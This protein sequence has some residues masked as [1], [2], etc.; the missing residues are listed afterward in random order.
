MTSKSEKI[1]HVHNPVEDNNDVTER[2]K[3]WSEV[4]HNSDTE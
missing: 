2:W 4:M 1:L 3:Y